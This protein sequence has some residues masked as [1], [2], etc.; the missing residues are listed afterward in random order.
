MSSLSK[1]ANDAWM[2]DRLYAKRPFIRKNGIS[3]S[4]T[5]E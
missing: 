2:T 4:I 3:W 5:N 1:A